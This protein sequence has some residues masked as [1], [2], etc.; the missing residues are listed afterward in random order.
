[1]FLEKEEEKEEDKDEEEE[2]EVQG[3]SSEQRRSPRPK[4]AIGN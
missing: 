3:I 1:M 4:F 2:E